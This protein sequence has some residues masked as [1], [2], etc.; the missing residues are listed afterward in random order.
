MQALR[1]RIQTLRSF[2]KKQYGNKNSKKQNTQ[3][4]SSSKEGLRIRDSGVRNRSKPVRRSMDVIKKE[5]NIMNWYSMNRRHLKYDGQLFHENIS[6]L[7]KV[8]LSSGTFRFKVKTGE[9]YDLAVVPIGGTYSINS[10]QQWI[11]SWFSVMLLDSH[12]LRKRMQKLRDSLQRS[13]P[14]FGINPESNI[15]LGTYANNMIMNK[16]IIVSVCQ[17]LCQSTIYFDMRI[18]RVLAKRF[19]LFAKYKNMTMT[20]AVLYLKQVK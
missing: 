8:N 10:K 3:I 17:Y 18:D 11:W 20:F 6:S 7:I 16:K 12:I 5:Q 9:V 4:S 1:S 13:G 19:D 14:I 15:R 2:I